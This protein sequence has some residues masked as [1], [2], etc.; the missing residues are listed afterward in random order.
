MLM[1]EMNIRELDRVHSWL[2]CRYVVDM[3]YNVVICCVCVQCLQCK[4]SLDLHRAM[5][6]QVAAN[7]PLSTCTGEYPG[8]T[9]CRC[10]DS[11]V[12]TIST[13]SAQSQ[14]YNAQWVSAITLSTLH[15]HYTL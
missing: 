8:S 9:H 15:L 11:N 10:R 7:S 13:F 5:Q 6:G 4:L 12:N 3:L 14:H 1:S 2:C